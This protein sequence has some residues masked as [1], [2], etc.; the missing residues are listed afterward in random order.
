MQS[1][2]SR[3]ILRS[4][5]WLVLP[6]LLAVQS[7]ALAQSA[8]TPA[9]AAKP[10]PAT[11]S[12]PKGEQR[13]EKVA[14]SNN[15]GVSLGSTPGARPAPQGAAGISSKAPAPVASADEKQVI[16]FDPPMA[17]LGD[18][19]VGSSQ[20]MII[21]IKNI[22]SEPIRI[23]QAV[24]GCG[25]TT[26]VWPR[27]PIAPGATADCEITMRPGDKG[28]ITLNKKVTFVIEN[29]P[30]AVL[31]VR[32]KAV[33]FI[34]MTPDI[35]DQPADMALAQP[36]TLTVESLDGVAFKI[37]E[38]MP[39]V[40]RK[41]PNEAA[42]KHVLEVDWANWEET[43]RQKRV[44]VKTDHPKG[45]Q[46]TTLV[47]RAINA[48]DPTQPTAPNAPRAA[49]GPG[50][51]DLITAVRAND[52]SKM[53]ALLAG[54]ADVNEQDR[55]GAR[56]A[57]HWAAKGGNK[58]AL[59]K[60][61]AAKADPNLKD[62]QGRTAIWGAVETNAEL[63]RYLVDN[64]ADIN[65]RDQ[66]NS[67]PLLW[68]AGFGR[69]DTVALLL[70][71]DADVKAVDD[72]G[73]TALIWAAG[74]GQPQ[75]VETLV[76]AGADLKAADRQTGDTPLLRAARTGK[77]ESIKILLD[78]GAELSARNK[79]QMT[80]LHLAAQSGSAEK[81]ALLL[82]SKADPAAVDSRNFTALDHAMART[83]GDKT[84]LIEILKPVSPAS[85]PATP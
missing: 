73:W 81:V 13:P 62:R 27:E 77:P 71:R 24:P 70:E 55:A 74:L 29:H 47:R 72:N 33:A 57:L 3:S 21:K 6:A 63:V 58:V 12:P 48:A 76:K 61:I 41:V 43:G 82:A 80:A 60:L 79:L 59:E 19:P 16:E 45:S 4:A 35:L 78:A 36:T 31:D 54:G 9:P 69:P 68:A 51:T 23:T 28:G 84:K 64:G 67:T 52:L 39:A 65:I 26:P 44:M 8:P 22:H 40:V 66:I 46:L 2:R 37:T 75:T 11:Q 7:S 85:K 83:T 20:S 14:P 5:S 49:S 30:S 10:E 1:A 15:S 56:T 38:V 25:C 34:Q 50:T 53:D 32:A 17:D 42:T 18:V